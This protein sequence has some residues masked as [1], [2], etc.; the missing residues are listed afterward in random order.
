MKHI[1]KISSLVVAVAMSFSACNK[2]EDLPNHG[3]GKAVVLSSSVS[4]VAPLPADSNNNV[5][6]FSWTDPAYAQ[7]P[8]L[9]KY[10]IEIDST[11]KGF[12]NPFRKVIVG[13]LSDTMVAKELNTALL[14]FG[15]EFNTAYVVDV[16]LVSSYGNN[17]EQYI[18]NTIQLNVTPYKVPPK[19]PVPANLYIVG[20]LN[21]WNNVPGL[22]TKYYFSLIDETTYAGIFNFTGGAY[23]LIQ[24]LGVWSSQYHMVAGGTAE[25]GEFI[26]ADADPAFPN[27]A[28]SG[29]Y[30]LTVDFQ[31]GT[32]SLAPAPERVATPAN[33]YLVG[34]INGWNNSPGLDPI[35]T[36]NNVDL[37]VKTLD[38]NFSSAGNYKLIQELGNWGTQ[39]HRTT[40][41]E[42]KGEFEQRDADPAFPAPGV[43]GTY[44]VK[45]NFAA[46]YYWLEKL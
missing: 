29:W 18:S 25:A 7:D 39:F 35:Y 14:G 22:D 10:V 36:F 41:D 24:E 21:G 17:N 2:V 32:Y 42:V 15:F 12:I 5:I 34:D 4:A 19:I 9:Y 20:D 23:K 30:R 46:N 28:T 16:R 8:A 3:N 26:Q 33:L 6:A 38:V 27:P 13:K 44:R 45:V 43:P 1:F 11:T 40:G 37:F 31:H